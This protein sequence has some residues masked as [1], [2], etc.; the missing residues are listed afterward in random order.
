[1]AT[2]QPWAAVTQPVSAWNKPLKA[3]FKAFFKEL[4]KA[5]IHAGAG[6]WDEAALD[7]GGMAQSLS[8]QTT[9]SELAWLLLRRALQ[10]ATMNLV[11]EHG[12]LFSGLTLE[13]AE[14]TPESIGLSLEAAEV[15]V[16]PDLFEHPKDCPVLPLFATFFQQWLVACGVPEARSQTI[17]D[18]LPTY[19][20]YALRGE[21]AKNAKAYE[22]IHA[23]LETP[24]GPAAEREWAWQQ[25][26][27]ELARQVDSGMLGETFSL[28]QVYVPLRAYYEETG[29]AAPRGSGPSM[30]REDGKRRV[31]VDLRT[32]LDTWLAQ[33]PRDDAIRVLS[34]G[35]GSGKSCFARLYAAEKAEQ[36][37][38]VL[39]VPL[40]LLDVAT[41]FE[42]AVGRFVREG[43]IFDFNPLDIEQHRGPL[44]IVLDGL[45]ELAMQGNAASEA[46]SKFLREVQRK[47]SS[48][49]Q[50]EA[51]LR[52]L[53]TGRELVVDLHA[54]EWRKPRQI[55]HLLPY[56]V[57]DA[58]S[59]HETPTG[60]YKDPEG[61]LAEDQRDSWWRQYGAAIGCQYEGLPVE[62]RRPE[63]REITAQPLLNYLVA[64]AHTRG[65]MDFA[66]A[67]NLNK[68]YADLLDAV[69]ERTYGGGPH[70][71]LENMEK[72]DFL[73]ILEEI[74]L[75]AWHGDGRTTTIRAIQEHC[76]NSGL[77]ALLDT[78]AKDAD[79][80][81]TRLLTAFYFRQ[82]GRS[83]D[84]ERTFE[85]T[86]KSFGE[87]LAAC[88]LV[89][90][91]T[92]IV[93]EL[94]ARKEDCDKGWDER[95]ALVH[96]AQVAGPTPLDPYLRRF[97]A[98]QLRLQ[99]LEVLPQWQATM[100]G[101]LSY[102]LRHGMPM[103]RLSPS[104]NS[105]HVMTR[106]ARNAEE[107]LLVVLNCV[108]ALT[109]VCSRND[110][111]SSTAAGEWIRR[112]QG[113]RAWDD[114][115]QLLDSLSFLNMSRCILMASDLLGA[116]LRAS[117]LAGA[118]M[119]Y[120]QLAGADLRGADLQDADLQDADLRCA[121]LRAAKLQGAKLQGANLQDANLQGANLQ[122][123]N[124]WGANLRGADLRGAKGANLDG[125]IVDD[126]T[127]LGPDP[128]E[129]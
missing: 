67:P 69:H 72:S 12:D 108:A 30:R 84:G 85:F 86:H 9:P 64:F 83:D 128:D 112:L 119:P 4:T 89:R 102:V 75:A 14:A 81:V 35:P 68:I 11:Q 104:V 58:R 70:P 32:E 46:A 7:I 93:R 105:Y 31:V 78:F 8:L 10:A 29:K 55:L 60:P 103:E 80:G 87:Y 13:A 26:A 5:A 92:K 24:F 127:L 126:T 95:E 44:L 41:D 113:Q 71:G 109:S 66:A 125:A 15:T 96:W 3:D 43:R 39:Y 48:R 115:H 97:I 124:L 116:N 28:R 1:M 120:A 27:D 51:L 79:V 99:A 61:L 110:W 22:P 23:S 73:R 42:A 74:G 25:Y 54:S 47:V 2:S 36:D 117:N 121:D 107:A 59:R 111:P 50:S 38:R 77:S 49:N 101:L 65:R 100:C 40:H 16:S 19:F 123:A 94:A 56:S 62:L 88:R 6:K 21:W 91:V 20:V 52:V 90:E 76:S 33:A 118:I 53:I 17:A 45:D 37:L 57:A 63:L 106:Q 129:D 122:G 114:C 18:R 82:Q 34:G 98:G